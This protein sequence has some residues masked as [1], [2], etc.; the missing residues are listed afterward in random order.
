VARRIRELVQR[1]HRE[2][3][4]TILMTTHNMKEA[5]S[6]CEEVAFIKGGTIQARGRPQDLKRELRLGDTIV[7]NFRGNLPSSPWKAWTGSTAF[8]AATLPADPGG[9]NTGS[10]FPRFS[11]G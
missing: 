1:L 8:N 2:K 4:T 3:G 5:E 7:V 10:G 9:T 6:L 11:T